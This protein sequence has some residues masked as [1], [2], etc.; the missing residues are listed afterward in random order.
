M[1]VWEADEE[2]SAGYFC[3]ILKECRTWTG[4]DMK[5]KCVTGIVEPPAEGF[6]LLGDTECKQHS[7]SYVLLNTHSTGKSIS[8]VYISHKLANTH[9]SVNGFTENIK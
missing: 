7:A 1:R 8:F 9:N 5:L 4:L 3:S 2:T 6:L